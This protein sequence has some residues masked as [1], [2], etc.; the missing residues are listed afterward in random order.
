MKLSSQLTDMD[1][2]LYSDV[3]EN[4]ANDLPELLVDIASNLIY[5]FKVIE[6]PK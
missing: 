3:A 1:G 6:L 5:G 2:Q 4:F